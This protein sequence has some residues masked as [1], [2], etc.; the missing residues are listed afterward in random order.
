MNADVLKVSLRVERKGQVRIGEKRDERRGV[1]KRGGGEERKQSNQESIDS[2]W[3]WDVK[4]HDFAR[5]IIL[6]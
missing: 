4:T 2:L 5:G 6:S 3:F 1:D